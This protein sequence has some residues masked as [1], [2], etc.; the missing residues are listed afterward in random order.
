MI[1]AKNAEAMLR[2]KAKWLG[3]PV[4]VDLTPPLDDA[5]AIERLTDHAHVI[6]RGPVGDDF[7]RGTWLLIWLDDP[8]MDWLESHTAEADDDGCI[9][10]DTE[11]VCEDEG[12]QCDDDYDTHSY[13]P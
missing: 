5:T 2:P 11:T 9:D 12:A 8:T 7:D 6:G 1:G 10:T 3:R 4:A 13:P